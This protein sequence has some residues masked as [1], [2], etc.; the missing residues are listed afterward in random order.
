MAVVPLGGR[1]VDHFWKLLNGLQIPHA[2]LL[3][4]DLGRHGGGWGRIK[5]AC[6]KLRD[7]GVNNFE[8]AD[9]DQMEKWDSAKHEIMDG[10][11]KH[12]RTFGVFFSEPLDLDM[13]MLKNF[14][15]KYRKLPQDGHGP[16]E[17]AGDAVKSVLGS[18]GNRDLCPD[19]T[20]EDFRWYRYLFITKSKPATHLYALSLVNDL[21]LWFDAPEPISALLGHVKNII[22]PPETT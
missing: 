2:T 10:W 6:L 17:G 16:L 13:S 21:G 20:D 1:H 19:L 7:N 18:N 4:L 8:G 3:D 14:S 5:N 9:I 22:T 12:L 11:I 15:D